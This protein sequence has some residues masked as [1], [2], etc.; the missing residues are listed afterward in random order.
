M[1]HEALQHCADRERFDYTQYMLSLLLLSSSTATDEFL[2]VKRQP[3]ET[4]AIYEP[5]VILQNIY[6]IAFGLILVC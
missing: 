5:N 2:H 3:F 1:D 4:M 6:D